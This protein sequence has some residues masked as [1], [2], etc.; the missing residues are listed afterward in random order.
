VNACVIE[1]ARL[2]WTK[3]P[4]APPLEAATLD[5]LKS[6]TALLRAHPQYVAP[7]AFVEALRG[8]V[9]RLP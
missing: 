7:G 4:A 9:A 2:G 8:I 1:P 5:R 3:H 6:A